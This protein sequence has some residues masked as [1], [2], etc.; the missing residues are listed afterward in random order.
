MT[1]GA[2][3]FSLMAPAK[4]CLQVC[5]GQPGM[6][7]RLMLSA[8]PAGPLNPR[9]GR[10]LAFSYQPIHLP[11]AL[12]IHLPVALAVLRHQ[13]YQA[14]ALCIS[15]VKSAARMLARA[16]RLH[17]VRGRKLPAASEW[18]LSKRPEDSRTV[19]L[20]LLLVAHHQVDAATRCSNHTPTQASGLRGID[21]AKRGWPS[22]P[23]LAHPWPCAK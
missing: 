3:A 10:T 2:T 22:L 15:P 18:E 4:G 21:E 14:V 7:A 23:R 11:V 5:V 16:S 8:H 19:I 6:A 12:A 1:P 17:L 9:P 13:P 20:C